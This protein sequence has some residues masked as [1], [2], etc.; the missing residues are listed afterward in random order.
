M[1]FNQK[2][3]LSFR[4]LPW[5]FT[6]SGHS[7]AN[8]SV[9]PLY[10]LTKSQFGCGAPEEFAGCEESAEDAAPAELENTGRLPTYRLMPCD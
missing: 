6:K 4:E 5:V 9:K 1:F 7:F 10:L 2:S 3:S 8:F